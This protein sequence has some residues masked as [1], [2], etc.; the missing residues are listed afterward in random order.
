MTISNRR[1][2]RCPSPSAK[3]ATIRKTAT[4]RTTDRKA[5]VAACN[6]RLDGS[7]GANRSAEA[8]RSSSLPLTRRTTLGSG[9]PSSMA[10][11]ESATCLT[12][13][14]EPGS[15]ILRR[16]FR[17]GLLANRLPLSWW[18]SGSRTACGLAGPPGEVVAQERFALPV[19]ALPSSPSPVRSIRRRW[20]G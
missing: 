11:T 20:H 1:S 3:T 6:Y 2:E 9:Q 7:R 16:W 19:V 5:N 13:R 8:R 14:R 18:R 12:R 4:T 17:L 10:S 15:S